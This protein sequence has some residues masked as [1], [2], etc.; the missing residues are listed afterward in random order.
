M[1]RIFIPIIALLITIGLVLSASPA[2]AAA[3]G[4]ES[5]KLKKVTFAHG[6]TDDYQPIN[7]GNQFYPDETVYL[8]VQIAGRPKSGVITARFFW[9]DQFIAEKGIDLAEV[10][11]GLIFSF[12]QDTYAG[13]T[14]THEQPF[15]ISPNYYAEVLFDGQSLGRYPFQAIPPKE[16]IPTQ[17]NALTLARGADEYYN[18]IEPTATFA[19]DETV[20]LVGNGNLGLSTWLQAEWYVNGVRDDAGT[21]SITMK[22]NRTSAG[23]SFSFLPDGGW[24]TGTHE[25]HLIVNDIEVTQQ[26]FTVAPHP[27]D[28]TAF[29]DRFPLPKDAELVQ[30]P[31]PYEGGFMTAATEPEIFSMYAD[32]LK[33]D[34]WIQKAPTEAM[35]T[36]PHQTWLTQGAELLIEI[37]G[38]DKQGRN[39]VWIR[40]KRLWP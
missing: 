2:N 7:P 25:V 37:R 8:S 4:A 10:N 1:K 21:R 38:Q 34:G 22:E 15:L 28:K 20:Y 40:L 39:E 27:F 23:F 36:L 26:P 18:P 33:N 16:A 3:P 14:L 19:Y 32:W 5:I 29:L 35:V 17:I 11:A 30:A 24:P 6:L 31:A 9:H 13:Y 12:G